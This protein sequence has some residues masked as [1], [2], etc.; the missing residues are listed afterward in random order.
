MKVTIHKKKISRVSFVLLWLVVSLSPFLKGWATEFTLLICLLWVGTFLK[1]FRQLDKSEKRLIAFG[2][3]FVLVN[4]VYKII[5]VSTAEWQYTMGYFQWFFSICLGVYIMACETDAKQKSI[6]VVAFLI[7]L[8][9]II[10]LLFVG[11]GLDMSLENNVAELADASYS[12]GLMLYSGILLVCFLNCKTKWVRMMTLL[13]IILITILNTV[14]LQRATNVILTLLMFVLIIVNNGKK[15]KSRMLLVFGCLITMI[16][17]STGVYIDILDFISNN[18]ESERVASRIDSISVFLQ[19]GD[20]IQA[21][22]S[23][24]T[25]IILL[26]TSWNTFR[27]SIWTILFGVGDHRIDT[28]IIGNHSEFIDMLAR[29]GI[30]GFFIFVMFFV[31]QY[32]FVKKKCIENSNEKVARQ[33]SSIF[34]VYVIRNIWGA[35]CVLVVGSLLFVVLPAMIKL[36][37]NTK[38]IL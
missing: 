30:L 25:R 35:S 13:V 19:T 14:Y 33:I 22:T 2:I 15:T 9:N 31:E 11:S 32:N 26:E 3:L 17:I 37:Y 21:G 28:S 5:G 12:S 6:V 27:E 24:R 20:H 36:L 7:M 38:K 29:F 1:R 10:I 16:V 4:L 18:L 8:I 23:I 34:L